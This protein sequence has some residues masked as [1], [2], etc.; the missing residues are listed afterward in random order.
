M[1]NDFISIKF[2]LHMGWV[3]HHLENGCKRN[4]SSKPILDEVETEN[5][6]THFCEKYKRETEASCKSEPILA[7]CTQENKTIACVSVHYVLV[8]KTL[9][10]LWVCSGP[11]LSALFVL[12]CEEV[13]TQRPCWEDH[14]TTQPAAVDPGPLAVRARLERAHSIQERPWP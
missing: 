3:L 8:W 9:S 1:L 13:S 11:V 4:R 5:T 10:L 6:L 14:N 2:K 12:V 7:R